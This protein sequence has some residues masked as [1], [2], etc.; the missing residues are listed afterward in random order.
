MVF[1]QTLCSFLQAVDFILAENIKLID[2]DK[3][4]ICR[5]NK[6]L[7]GAIEPVHQSWRVGGETEARAVLRT[8]SSC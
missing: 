5:K 3:K 2:N 4:L 6:L 8:G 7:T 1:R